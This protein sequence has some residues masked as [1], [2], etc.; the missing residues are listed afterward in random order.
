MLDELYVLPSLPFNL[1]LEKLF[2]EVKIFDD[3][4]DLIA[5]ESERL[6]QFVENAD[7]VDDKAVRLDELLL[8]VLIGAVNPGD[9]LQQGVVAHGLVEIHGVEDRCIEAG[10]E[11]LRDNEDLGLFAKPR[12]TLPDSSLFLFVDVKLL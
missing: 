1:C 3:G 2:K 8:F 12:K 4:I 11:L 5:V 7:K 10:Q 9:R 6:F